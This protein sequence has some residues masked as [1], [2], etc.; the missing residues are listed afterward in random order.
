VSALPVDLSTSEEDRE[1]I[2]DA[3]AQLL[4]DSYTL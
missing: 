2:A 3:L 4:A 1:K